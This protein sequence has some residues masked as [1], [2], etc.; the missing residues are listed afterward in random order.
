MTETVVF[1]SLAL[2]LLAAFAILALRRGHDV[3]GL[4]QAMAALHS[5]DIEAFRNLLSVE[6]EEFLRARLSPRQFIDLRRERVR[7]ALAYVKVLS[8]AS[9]Q[10]ARFAGAAQRSPDPAIAASG[11]EIA[12]SAAYLRLRALDANLRLRLSAFFPTLPLHPVYPL[13]DQ[14][15]RATYLML[16]HNGLARSAG[17]AS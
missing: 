15:D 11:K 14:Y 1:I 6:E 16:R 7:A 17:R 2:A 10:F 13:L 3:P 5:L 8:D 12:D 9:L 4:E